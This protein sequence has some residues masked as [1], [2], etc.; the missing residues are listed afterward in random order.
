MPGFRDAKVYPLDRPD[1]RR[2]KALAKGN[3]RGGKA[4][5]YVNGSARSLW[6]SGSWWKSSSR[7]SGSTW[8]FRGSRSTAR[9]RRT[10]TSSPLQASR[11]TS[12]SASGA[13]ATSTRTRTSTCSS[14][15]VSPAPRTSAALPQSP[16]DEQM[17][18]AALAPPGNRP[19]Q[20]LRGTRLRPRTRCCAGGAGR[21][22]QRGDAHLGQRRMRR[23]QT[24][25][26]SDVGLPQRVA[27]ARLRAPDGDPDEVLRDR[28]AGGGVAGLDRRD[29][30]VRRRVDPRDRPRR[31]CSPP[32]ST[33]RRSRS[34]RGRLPP[35]CRPVAPESGSIRVTKSSPA[36]ATQSAPSAKTIPVGCLP[37][38]KV[39]RSPWRN[40]SELK[41]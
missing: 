23:A 35:G 37:T 18:R 1:L 30:V 4:L 40:V 9:R 29:D 16:Y 19:Q 7:R 3:L 2:A 15:A 26:R 31:A 41:R 6:R 32:R 14:T 11:G 38:L 36:F 12:R 25:A 10:S 34:P 21:L 24:G 27:G 8:R 39:P 28:D 33:R 20:R 22:P 13:R 5:L 17:R